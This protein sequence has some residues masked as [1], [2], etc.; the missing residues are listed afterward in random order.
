M[1]EVLKIETLLLAFGA[2]FFTFLTRRIGEVVAPTLSPKTPL[3]TAQNVWERLVLPVVP[4]LYGVVLVHLVPEFGYPEL[5][6]TARSRWV[7]GGLVGFFSEWLYRYLK[8]LLLS[9]L[10]VEAPGALP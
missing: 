3:T 6:K 8:N 5:L 9:R 2:Y 1:D 4:V 7:F 10:K